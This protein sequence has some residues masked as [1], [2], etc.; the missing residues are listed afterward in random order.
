MLIV[1]C[2]LSSFEHTYY[3]LVFFFGIFEVNGSVWQSLESIFPLS[4]VI[5]STC[6]VAQ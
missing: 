3:F 6:S 2:D 5:E 4:R 1:S